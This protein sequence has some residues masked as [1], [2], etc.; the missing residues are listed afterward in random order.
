MVFKSL[1]GPA[2]I[3]RMHPFRP[4]VETVLYLMFLESEHCLPLLRKEDL[5]RLDVPIPESIVGTAQGQLPALFTFLQ[6]HLGLLAVGNIA[7]ND[8]APLYHSALVF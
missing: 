5:V 7:A 2:N 3:I 6:R 8:N 4:F 1:D